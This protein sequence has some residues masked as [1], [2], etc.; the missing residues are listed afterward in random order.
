MHRW[1]QPLLAAW[2]LMVVAILQGG[3]GQQSPDHP[4]AGAARQDN[5]SL[6]VGD[7]GVAPSDEECEAFGQQFATAVN[8]G[9]LATLD[10]LLDWQTVVARA[11]AGI[12]VPQKFQAEFSAGALN[13]LRTNGNPLRILGDSV[14]NGA[15]FTYVRTRKQDQVHV[16]QF[17][18]LQADGGADYYQIPLRKRPPE[19]VVGV[20][21]YTLSSG[22]TVSEALRRFY[23]AAAAE[24][25]Q[26]LIA[27]LT[28]AEQE[29]IKHSPQ[30]AAMATAVRQ[31]EPVDAL[32]IYAKLPVG[33][34]QQKSVQLL[35]IM[36]SQNIDESLYLAALGDFRAAHP[37]DPCVDFLSIDYFFM[38]NKFDD[39]IQSISRSEQAIGGDPYF[40]VLRAQAL[41][42]RSNLPAAR[43]SAE[44]ARKAEPTLIDAYWVLVSIS[45]VE[46]DFAGTAELLDQ[47]GERFGVEF[48]DVSTVE[49]YV[50]FSASPAGQAWREK[51]LAAPPDSE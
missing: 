46:K 29:L 38:K 28:G 35:R 9:D 3:C 26:G 34:Q 25:N 4:A 1:L 47:I 37:K 32:E 23:L 18:V 8:A 17:R 44:R 50:E 31:E 11:T 19:T 21:L 36:A 16:A 30:L 48:E 49:E 51:Q 41:L 33:I 40:D 39:A 10:R 43:Q 6:T 15:R 27:R 14:A 2:G 22:E 45:L 13:S 7:T 20:D 42:Q 5:P 24:Q 12:D